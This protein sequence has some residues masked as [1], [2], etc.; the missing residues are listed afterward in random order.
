MSQEIEERIDRTSLLRNFAHYLKGVK[1]K[2]L[3]GLSLYDLMELYIG[4]V[5]GALSNRAGSIAFSFFMA[6]FPFALFIFNLIP[7]IPIEGFQQDF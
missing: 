6:L 5:E 4:I 1:L 7:Y 3:G 2:W